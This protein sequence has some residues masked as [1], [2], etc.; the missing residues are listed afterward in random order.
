MGLIEELY[1]YEIELRDGRII[2]DKNDFKP[3][4]VVRITYK[5][6]SK[7]LPSHTLIFYKDYRYVKR[8]SRTFMKQGRG[9]FER[10]H[11]V[12]TDKFRF[13]LFSTSGKILIVDKNY[14]LYI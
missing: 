6:K 3:E 11:C 9:V 4:E 8:F 10:V 7:V 14:E 1:S 5:P 13:Y 12:I 2:I